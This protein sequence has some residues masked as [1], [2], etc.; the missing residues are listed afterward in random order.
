M[1]LSCLPLKKCKLGTTQ[2]ASCG[3]SVGGTT[4]SADDLWPTVLRLHSLPWLQN[5]RVL[6]WDGWIGK[7][8]VSYMLA[9]ICHGPPVLKCFLRLGTAKPKVFPLL[10]YNP[11][12][13]ACS[14]V[15]PLQHPNHRAIS[16]LGTGVWG[17]GI[18]KTQNHQKIWG[19]N[20]LTI[21][22]FKTLWYKLI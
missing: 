17:Y 8:Q 2:V 11:K 13:P 5:V 16:F 1:H 15:G 12:K 18:P 3:F 7:G 10:V 21:P 9:R 14:F 22:K 4:S 20:F 6:D 19:Y